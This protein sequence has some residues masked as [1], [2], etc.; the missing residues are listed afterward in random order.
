VKEFDGTLA[1]SRSIVK[2]GSHLIKT[3][4]SAELSRNAKRKKP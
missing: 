3:Y 4:Y 1:N 2:L